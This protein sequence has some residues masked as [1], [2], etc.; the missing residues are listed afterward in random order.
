MM[1]QQ[2]IERT[3]G[4]SLNVQLDLTILRRVLFV[5]IN[6]DRENERRERERGIAKRS[7]DTPKEK[8]Q[9]KNPIKNGR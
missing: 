8:F 1:Q 3:F 5:F 7:V 2:I 9:K 4:E 6:D